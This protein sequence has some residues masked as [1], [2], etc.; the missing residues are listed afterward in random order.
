YEWG[1]E[2]K[3]QI[4]YYGNRFVGANLPDNPD[5][6]RIAQDM[7][8]LGFTVDHPDQVGDVVREAVASGRPCVI[9][10]ILEGGE[11]VLAEPFRRDALK[12]PVRYLDKYKH[13]NA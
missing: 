7:G 8:A 2:K 12:M 10:A 1:A 3:N 6:A 9:N 5:F 13:L 4:D 11:R